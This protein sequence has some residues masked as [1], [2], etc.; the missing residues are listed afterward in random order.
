MHVQFGRDLASHLNH[1]KDRPE[2]DM[3]VKSH[4]AFR[5]G[6]PFCQHGHLKPSIKSESHFIQCRITLEIRL[7]SMSPCHSVRPS[8]RVT[9]W[10]ASI[11]HCTNGLDDMIETLV[12]GLRPLSL[13]LAVDW[14]FHSRTTLWTC[15][16]THLKRTCHRRIFFA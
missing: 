4:D 16:T 11:V 15:I 8:V 6:S 9:T 12:H 1:N 3:A 13:F 14:H 5:N 2:C 7:G 10:D